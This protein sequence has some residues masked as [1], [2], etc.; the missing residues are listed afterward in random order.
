M[1]TV[2]DDVLPETVAATEEFANYHAAQR[3]TSSVCAACPDL[4]VCGGGM[5]AHRWRDD[6]GLDN[7]T[8]FCAD[9]QLLI[10]KVRHY[11]RQQFGDAA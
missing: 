2:G 9:Q 1:S 11:L 4:A 5:P 10:A 8:I 7:P 3:P 6:N